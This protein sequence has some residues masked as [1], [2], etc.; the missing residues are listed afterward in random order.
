[1]APKVKSPPK[2][3]SGTSASTKKK[4]SPGSDKK[5]KKA[6][7]GTKPSSGTEDNG[8]VA[9][10]VAQSGEKMADKIRKGME[11]D[12]HRDAATEAH[13]GS[14]ANMIAAKG[15]KHKAFLEKGAKKTMSEEQ[16]IEPS[17]KYEA[18]VKDY[19]DRAMEV[20]THVADGETLLSRFGGALAAR[21]V[22]GKLD[23]KA[24]IVYDWD[25]NKDGKLSLMEFRQQVKGV[26]IAEQDVHKIDEL[27]KMWDKD[28]SGF[29]EIDELKVAFK[30]AM[31]AYNAQQSDATE[32]RERAAKMRQVARLAQ[33]VMDR[34]VELEDEEKIFGQMRGARG[35][36]LEEKI[37]TKLAERNARI[38]TLVK[39]D[40]SGDGLMDRQ[41]F[42]DF[43]SSLIKG[44][45]PAELD[46][47]Y[48]TLD[49]DG[50]GA[51]D[52]AELKQSLHTLQGAASKAAGDLADQAELL[53]QMVKLV[54]KLQ[55]RFAKDLATAEKEFADATVVLAKA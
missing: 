16:S 15:A 17:I 14:S 33:E 21:N 53:A 40:S 51:L 28:S 29:L 20:D 27:F 52:L 1:M 50:S 47:L 34:T 13:A 10:V 46:R 18:L 11:G 25:K 49:K 39:A 6:T 31:V 7:A 43:A 24:S 4:A 36:T 42:R 23:Q 3:P 32:L 35:A 38:D 2:Q 26:G 8:G 9:A 54:G 12:G 22:G 45:E 55:T 30:Q 41:E 48:G 44:V 19:E 5:E 37:G